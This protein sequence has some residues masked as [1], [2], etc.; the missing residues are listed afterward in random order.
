MKVSDFSVRQPVVISGDATVAAAAALMA[1]QGVGALIVVDHERPVGI[2][3]DR[4]IVTRGI[5]KGITSD[6]R[7]D[8]LMSTDLVSLDPRAELEDLMHVFMHHAVRRVP[9]VEHG[10]VVGVVS[11]DDVLVAL[12]NHMTDITN[13]VAA[14]IMFPHGHDAPPVPAPV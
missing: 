3:T 8:A 7:V 12:T 11:M 2:V 5:A 6:A 13:V 1:A 14:Q 10:K 9:I 4:D